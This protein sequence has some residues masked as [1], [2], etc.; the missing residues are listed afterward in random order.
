MSPVKGMHR[1]VRH[2]RKY[3]SGVSEGV[4]E[5][6][7]EIHYGRGSKVGV[8]GVCWCVSWCGQCVGSC[9]SADSPVS[10]SPG[11]PIPSLSAAPQRMAPPPP[12]LP[13][14]PPHQCGS[15]GENINVF[16]DKLKQ[17]TSYYSP[18]KCQFGPF[19][20]CLTFAIMSA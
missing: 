16:A 3:T 6:Q 1:S 2:S 19:G 17:T 5:K 14:R 11:P 15:S 10:P 18:N 13:L 9:F 12:A 20:D 4:R 7:D 8:G